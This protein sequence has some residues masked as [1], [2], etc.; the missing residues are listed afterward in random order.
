VTAG[1]QDRRIPAWAQAL[2]WAG[3]IVF[4]VLLFRKGLDCWFIADDFAWLGLIRQVSNSH[5]LVRVLFEPAAQGTVRPWS[6]RGFFLLFE[7]LF[8]LD[9]LPFRIMTFATMA[10]NLL[11]LNWITRRITRSA[12]AG[13][14]AALCWAAN[15]ALMVVMTWSSAYN[16]AM[17]SLFLLGAISL[18]IRFVETGSRKFW[19]WQAVVFTLGFG[20]L[21]TDVVY[22]AL[23]A[24]YALFVAPKDK[25]RGLLIGLLPLFALSTLYFFWHRAVSPLPTTGVY[26]LHVDARIL[27]TLMLYGKW[28]LL[29]VDFVAFGH[30][31]TAG[32]WILN[33]GLAGVV[34][35]CIGEAI[36]RR[37]TVLFFLAWWLIA[38]APVLVLPDHMTDYY[39]TIPLIGLAMMFGYGVTCGVR[40]LGNWRWLALIP[41]AAYLCGMIP[42]SNSATNWSYEKTL[43]IRGIVLG[44]EAAREKHPGKAILLDGLSEGKYN[45]SVG[46]GA[47]YATG[48]ENVY[49]TPES[50]AS[51]HNGPGVGDR[52]SAVLDPEVTLHAI[53]KDQVVIYSVAGDHLRN[54]T[55]VYER[56]APNR[57][58]DRLP[59]RVDAGNPLYSWLLGPSWLAPD[60]GVRWMPGHATVRLRGPEARGAKLEVQGF[61]PAE[62]LRRVARVLKIT[63]DGLPV[64][65]L[66]IRDPE[67]SFD[68]L[69]VMPDSLVG[70]D[71]VEIGLDA[72]PVDVRGGQ[73]YGMVFG[74]IAVRP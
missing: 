25:R 1:G 42:I 31:A 55:E 59:S 15:T 3:P 6:E 57:S 60:S 41:I 27:H 73:E 9:A 69:F 22:P 14:V 2:L 8:G 29:P 13:F 32:K 34:A 53:E 74:K 50:G 67:S 16:E 70:R 64:G 20:A 65:E 33:L 39:L 44:V 72:G 61:F 68:R 48:V 24:S 63:A 40:D 36:R 58:A 37:V 54:V 51:V 4:L 7:T 47:F 52:E 66:T 35:L 45:D 30:S 18:F 12:F 71:A 43:P 10:A 38:L 62:Q 56:S 5:D 21:E 17:C 49:L 19:W 23:A 46:Q 11:L 28:S 26:A